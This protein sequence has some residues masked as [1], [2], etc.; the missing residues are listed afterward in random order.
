[1][2][3]SK[4][5]TAAD[6]ASVSFCTLCKGRIGYLEKTLP[7]NLV[8]IQELDAELVLLDYRSDDGLPDWVKKTFRNYIDRGVLQFIELQSDIPFSIPIGKNFAHRLGIKQFLINLDA[9][10]F[11]GD[12][13]KQAQRA[14]ANEFIACDEFGRGTFG[15]IGFWRQSLEMLGGY[16]EALQ[17]AGHQD[18]DLINRALH[19]GMRKKSVPASIPAIQNSKVETL[20]YMSGG[21]QA[22]WIKM[23]RRNAETSRNNLLQGKLRANVSGWTSAR[24]RKNFSE[25][26]TLTK[27]SFYYHR[28]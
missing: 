18:F 3:T 11:I 19:L 9:D 4:K 13:W 12:L 28:I 22:E 16:D 7:A 21:G 1:M 6:N 8:Q 10:N 20:K 15:R 23:E 24:F 27:Q 5:T 17:P 26:I 25:N 14:T 2:R